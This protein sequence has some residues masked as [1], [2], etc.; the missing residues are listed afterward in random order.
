MEVFEA[1]ADPTRREILA[2]LRDRE[3]TAGDVAGAFDVSRPAISRH[4]RVLRECGLVAWRGEGQRRIYRLRAAPLR[5]MQAW[6]DDYRAFWADRLDALQQHVEQPETGER[7]MD[8]RTDRL[9]TKTAV[10]DRVRLDFDRVVDA[11]IERVWRALVEPAEA[12]AWWG[13][14]SVTVEPGARYLLHGGT[15]PPGG[16]ITAWDPPRLLAF[17]W[18]RDETDTPQVITFR[19]EAD[20]ERTRLH[21]SHEGLLPHWSEQVLP[22]WHAVLVALEAT[23]AGEPYDGKAIFEAVGPRYGATKTVEEY[24]ERGRTYT[25]PE[26]SA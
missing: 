13:V 26:T 17:E 14:A 22:G 2:L 10:G 15:M 11:P 1:V 4:L 6:L 24:R 7:P 23:I 8:L 16:P 20:G 25:P 12:A 19:L 9:G 21:F 18:N 5:D 3:R